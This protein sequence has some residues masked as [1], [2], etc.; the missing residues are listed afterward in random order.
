MKDKII[1]VTG[2]TDGIGKQTAFDLAKMGATVLI[3]G[4]DQGRCKRTVKEIKNATGNDSSE[5]FVSDL[6]SMNQVRNLADEIKSKHEKL[7]VLINNA[8]IIEKRRKITEDGYEMTFAINHL[9]YF[10]LTGLLLDLLIENAPS[11]IVNVSSMAHSS[12]IDFDNLHGEKYFDGW[13][14]YSLSKLC[15]ILFT[16]ELAERLK[17]MGVTANCL[18]PGMINTKLLRMNFS[19]G[20]PVSEGS[21]TSVYLTTAPE[22]ENVTGKYFVEKRE[23]RSASISYNPDV[24]KKL[25]EMSEQMT[26]LNF[27]I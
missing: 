5:F 19:S 13:E 7:N 1:L 12:N 14:A 15:N 17:G 23:T 10:L 4:R 27:K 22:L 11:R 24:R 18:H 16:Y 6:S 3:H 9:A 20:R 8:G 26:D 21:K 25:W 2:S